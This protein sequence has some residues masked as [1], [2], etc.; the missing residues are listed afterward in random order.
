MQSLAK[1]GTLPAGGKTRH[2]SVE[3]WHLNHLLALLGV[4]GLSLAAIFFRLS[5]VSPATVTVTSSQSVA[6]STPVT[7]TLKQYVPPPC[8]SVGVKVKVPFVIV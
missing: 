6:P 8:N 3:G 4:L 5:A 7:T 2:R 1:R